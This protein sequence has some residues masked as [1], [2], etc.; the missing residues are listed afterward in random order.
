MNFS[1]SQPVSN[2]N[3]YPRKTWTGPGPAS[4]GQKKP[5]I[6]VHFLGRPGSTWYLRNGLRRMA[7]ALQLPCVQPGSLSVS[8][9]WRNVNFL[10]EILLARPPMKISVLLLSLLFVAA[11]FAQA[12]KLYFTDR[13]AGRVQ[14]ADLDGSNIETLVMLPGSNLRGITLNLPEGKMYFCDNGGDDIYRASLEDRTGY[15]LSA[16]VWDF[17][18]ISPWTHSRKSSTGAIGTMI[19]SSGPISMVAV[20]RLSLRQT[21]PTI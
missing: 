13:G 16:P 6:T 21:S 20:V 4:T 18:P 8:G 10:S 5:L 17:L 19:A 15:Q 7:D 1:T 12:G 14:R 2:S 11:P 9:L 3:S